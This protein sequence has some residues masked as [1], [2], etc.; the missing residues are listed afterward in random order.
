MFGDCNVQS[1]SSYLWKKSEK[2]MVILSAPWIVPVDVTVICD[3]S[4]VIGKGKIVDIGKRKNILQQYPHS[5]EISYSCVL[6]PGLVNAHMHLEL[7]YLEKNIKQLPE[8]RFTDWIESLIEQRS[9]QNTC[10]EE[11]VAAFTKTLNDQY[12]AGVALIGDIGNEYFA[13]LYHG[14]NTFQP[15]ILR[16]LEYLAP[17]LDACRSTLDKLKQLDQQIAVTGHAPYSTAPELLVEIKKRCNR[18]QHIFSVHVSE[19]E[20]EKEFI[21]TGK[22][23]FRE[24]LEK[25]NSWDGLFPFSESGFTGTV[26]YFDSLG[27]L[28]NKTLLVH[29]VHIN[30]NEIQLLKER[31]CHICLCPGSN[32]FLGVGRAPVEQMVAFGLLPALGSDS[33]ASNESI[34]MWREMQILTTNHPTLAHSDV[35]AMAT[36]GGAEALAFERDF[37]SL[38]VGKSANLIH[39]SSANL[40][41]CNDISSVI[42]ELVAGGKPTEIEWVFADQK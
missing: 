21:Q 14:R 22:G 6:M 40:K 27:L 10:R 1:L 41:R 29:C 16:M 23:C 13:E 37:G 35:L 42:K 5:Q 2:T 26:E 32:Q 7:S 30:A 33:P 34:D 31:G 4:I 12:N 36:I 20:G 28:D 38:A 9:S 17:T 11:I 3:G 39:V 8:Q 18:F 24:F 15:R 25:K 19:S